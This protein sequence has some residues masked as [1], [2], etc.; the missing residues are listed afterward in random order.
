[1]LTLAAYR[2]RCSCEV[3]LLRWT[4]ER[5][6]AVIIIAMVRPAVGFS[7]LSSPRSRWNPRNIRAS[8]RQ[9]EG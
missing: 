4:S 1:M 6:I 9:R 5:G 2:N 7:G 8:I 3:D